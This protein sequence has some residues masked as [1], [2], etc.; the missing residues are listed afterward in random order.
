MVTAEGTL[1]GCYLALAARNP[2]ARP[3]YGGF[4]TVGG[5]VSD[6]YNGVTPYNL[7]E[8]SV[9]VDGAVQMNFTY[10]L[11]EQVKAPHLPWLMY[12]VQMPWKKPWMLPT[13]V[14]MKI[15]RCPEVGGALLL[16]KAPVHLM[17]SLYQ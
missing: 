14:V 15:V 9:T 12:S 6:A 7:S 5:A 8:G 3:S 1:Y 13:W 17:C 2:Q 10:P 4:S 16:L 11:L